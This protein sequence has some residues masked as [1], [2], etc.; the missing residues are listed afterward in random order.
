MSLIL[1]TPAHTYPVDVADVKAAARIDHSH[2]DAHIRLLLAAATEVAEVAT[3]RQLGTATY[4]LQSPCWPA[5]GA[6][7]RLPRPPLQAVLQVQ[8]RDGTGDLQTWDE[9]SYQVD[10]GVLLPTL[11]PIP[12]VSWPSIGAGWVDAVRVT[13]RAGYESPAAVPAAIKAAILQMVAAWLEHPEGMRPTT[14]D[15]LPVGVRH[16][17]WPYAIG[18]YL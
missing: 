11:S 9:D 5:N 15:S 14:L 18:E 10:E 1:V 8:Y 17:L 3:G 7:I 16:L 13:Y 2:L 6:P 12:A 4:R